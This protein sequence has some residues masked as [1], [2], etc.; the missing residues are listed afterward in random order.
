MYSSSCLVFLHLDFLLFCHKSYYFFLVPI[1]HQSIISQSL[2]LSMT[3]E[4]TST[5]ASPSNALLSLGNMLSE[6]IPAS[7]SATSV[8]LAWKLVALGVSWVMILAL[9]FLLKR[10]LTKSA[11]GE[12]KNKNHTFTCTTKT[13]QGDQSN[14]YAMIS[15]I[16]NRRSVFPNQYDRTA[17]PVD[18]RIVD[19]L[20]QAAQ[21]APYHGK[22][23]GCP[24]PARFVLLGKQ[25]MVDMQHVT[26]QYYDKH[27]KETNT[28]DSHEQYLE[29]R[30][31]TRD[32]ITGRWG[33]VS[34]MIA[35]VLRRST[36]KECTEVHK[37]QQQ[38]AANQACDESCPVCDISASCPSFV[39]PE[40]EDVAA[41]AA[42]VQNITC[43]V[44]N[45]RFWLATGVPGMKRRVRVRP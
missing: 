4:A 30:Q 21:W 16:R 19:S 41:V 32:E 27:W 35:I 13:D 31:M 28:F 25:A 37:Q 3:M 11:T 5:T 36:A 34:Y 18:R 40:W 22:H 23:Y 26:L 38:Q 24:H 6:I 42:S 1:K 7:H 14:P 29:W 12:L 45:F 15:C 39:L 33:P 20:L 9:A 44:P 8:G 10:E 2:S 43:K 17:P